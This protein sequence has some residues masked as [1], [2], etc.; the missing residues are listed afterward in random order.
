M[1][2]TPQAMSLRGVHDS[3]VKALVKAYPQPENVNVLDL[4][5]GQGALTKQIH[6][7]G[8][9]THACEMNTDYY[10]FDKVACTEANVAEAL[11][12]EENTF[13]AIASAEVIEHLIDQNK[14]FEECYRI[15]KPGGKLILSTP[16]IL[17]LKSRLQFFASGYYWSF[18]PLDNQD[19]SGLQHVTA[20]TAEQYHYIAHHYGFK[21]SD[22]SVDKYQRS[23]RWLLLLMPV[24]YLV[25][26]GMLKNFKRQNTKELLL[27]RVI[28]I[29]FDK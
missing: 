26:W 8:Y 12:Y 18:N 29:S 15:L 28:V 22:I 20:R 14:F 17:S 10:V 1:S 25:S 4:G 9:T 23:S 21:L 24:M 11:P 7:L 2:T 3:V 19:R 13:D 6:E 27:G 5:A 16:N